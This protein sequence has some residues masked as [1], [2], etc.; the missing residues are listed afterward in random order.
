MSVFLLKVIALVSMCIDHWAV[1]QYNM[2]GT[3]VEFLRGIGRIAFP[4]YL[5][6]IIN[7]YN[8]T[9]SFSRYLNTVGKYALISQP[10]YSFL[11]PDKTEIWSL[12]PGP[13]CFYNLGRFYIEVVNVYYAGISIIA[14]ALLFKFVSQYSGL[15]SFILIMGNLRISYGQWAF[16]NND[17][18]ILCT[19]VICLVLLEIL[20]R[21]DS[22]TFPQ[23]ISMLL[24]VFLV[25]CAS[26]AGFV[27][28]LVIIL[29]VICSNDKYVLL[30]GSCILLCLR[31][32]IIYSMPVWYII[33]VVL[34][35]GLL[36]LYNNER[37]LRCKRFFYWIYPIHMLILVIYQ[38]IYG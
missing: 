20:H 12:I 9:R 38:Q 21:H 15:L 26:D 23:F 34:A 17:L 7:G 25:A 6:L 1:V 31:N 11:F 19:F 10:I 8:H 2:H 16:L 37:G 29:S 35:F 28:C 14:I 36:F 18:N 30:I 4:I 5:L 22:Y 24:C 3:D 13:N 32:T 33:P 27:S